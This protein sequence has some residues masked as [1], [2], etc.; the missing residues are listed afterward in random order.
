[1]QLI[2]NNQFD[3]I[4]H[5]HFSYFSLFTLQKIFSKHQLEIFDVQELSTHG[6]SLRIYVKHGN[7]SIENNTK[8][9]SVVINKEKEAELDKIVGYANF[10]KKTLT[11]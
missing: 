9:I 8:N 11:Q 4:Y 10:Q 6:G 5:E 7:S 2:I 1:M 3:T